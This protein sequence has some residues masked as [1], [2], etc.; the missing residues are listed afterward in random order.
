M[1]NERRTMENLVIHTLGY[2]GATLAEFITR[3]KMAGIMTVA[4]VRQMPL[5]RKR[6]FSKTALAAALEK[7]GIDYVHI[8]ALGCPKPI[9]ERY[10]LDGDWSAYAHAF[11]KH[12]DASSAAVLGLA[13]LAVESRI[14]LVCFEADFSHCHR[15]IVAAAASTM[16]KGLRAIHLTI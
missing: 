5:S 12:L 14:C 1:E 6:G 7:A 15:S 13:R 11:G 3:L 2:E 10:R 4:D 16:A 8:P 9:R